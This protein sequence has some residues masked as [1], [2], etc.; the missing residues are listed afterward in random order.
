MGVTNRTISRQWSIFSWDCPSPFTK[1][2]LVFRRRK[3]VFTGKFSAITRRATRH[4]TRR[5]A[6]NYTHAY[7]NSF[8]L[9]KHYGIT[10]S[11][12]N[13]Q[14]LIYYHFE[15]TTHLIT[16]FNPKVHKRNER[17]YYY[18]LLNFTSG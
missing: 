14:R 5:H 3:I 17:L 8:F 12:T 15:N 11:S 10:H 7:I 4:K 9:T 1:F 6:F 13:S 18:F 2:I 16:D